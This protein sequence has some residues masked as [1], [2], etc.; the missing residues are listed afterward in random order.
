MKVLFIYPNVVRHPVD[1]SIGIAYLAAY[2]KQN[3]HETGLLD[4]SFGM[5]DREILRRVRQFHPDLIA[6]SSTSACIQYAT[7]VAELIKQVD[8]TPIVIGGVHPTV[9]PEST[10]KKECFDM[11][12]VGEGEEA[13]LELTNS[14]EKGEV[15]TAISN[16][17]FK[18]NG[19]IIRNRPRPLRRDLDSLPFPD[20]KIYDFERYMEHH[21][22]TASFLG[23]RGCPFR[24]SY[25]INAH[26]QNLYKGLGPYVRYRSVDKII[27]EIKS[28]QQEFR[29]DE[30]NFYDDTFTL[31]ASRVEEFCSRFK[32]A[33][34]VPFHINARLDTLSDDICR[35]LAG[36]GCVRIQVGLES[37]DPEIR[38][39]ILK[40]NITDEQIIQGAAWV[41]KY[42]IQLYTFNMIGIPGENVQHIKKTIAMNRRIRPDYLAVSIFTAYQGTELHDQCAEEGML[43][44]SISPHTYYRSSNVNHPDL[45]PAQLRRIWRWFG[46]RVFAAFNMKRAVIEFIDR[47][48]I[49]MPYYEWVRSF[50]VTRIK[51]RN[52]KNRYSGMDRS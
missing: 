41:R 5:R 48:L 44:E 11:V 40:K 17:W 51:R 19:R 26:N 2:L 24:C 38:E 10:L 13:L 7:Y 21:N 49:T 27:E 25:C 22:R 20:L 4:T 45:S 28:V 36:A 50:F 37:G 23:S 29:I 43:D 16:I 6:M 35:H 3:G 30:V 18:E 39:G 14:L 8:K 12:C 31:K 32:E 15:T 33:V 52:K 42:G 46:F 47:S 9:A 1:L 34:G